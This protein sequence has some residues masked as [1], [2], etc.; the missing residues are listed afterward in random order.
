[1][2]DWRAAFVTGGQSCL[3]LGNRQAPAQLGAGLCCIRAE[4]GCSAAHGIGHQVTEKS[5]GLS[6]HLGD[7]WGDF[8]GDSPR[9]NPSRRPDGAGAAA[10]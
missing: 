6:Q 5:N 7:F 9:P 8:S 10:W 2:W 1:M 4:S 3:I